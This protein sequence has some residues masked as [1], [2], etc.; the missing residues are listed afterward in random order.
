[1][2]PVRLPPANSILATLTLTGGPAPMRAGLA[3]PHG[4]PTIRSYQILRTDE[5]DAKDAPLTASQRASIVAGGVAATHAPGDQFGGK[6]RKAAKLS[7]PDA[8]IESVAT[9]AALIA[10][11]PAKEKMTNHNP[12]IGI[13]PDS[14]RVS[15]EMR[16]VGVSAFLYAAS[17]EGD[18]DFHLI[19]GE[20]PS[21]G[22]EEV[23]I[24]MEVSGLP[25][26][27]APS[28]SAITAVRDAFKSFFSD[29]LPGATYD[30][31]N[32]PVPMKIEGAV[33]FDMTHASGRSP[34]PKTL[35]PHMPVIWEVHPITK[36]EFEPE[37]T[38]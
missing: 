26:A 19:V 27:D 34:G 9:I 29:Q 7:I 32:P 38:S 22:G 33:F 1:M 24:T 28:H 20:D 14:E 37:P 21:L 6:D 2:A 35:H 31:Y 12:H 13:D 23:Y 15:E 36:L 3:A 10:S 5:V 17:R 8:P 18:N 25:P 11:L 4:A 30:F 16:N